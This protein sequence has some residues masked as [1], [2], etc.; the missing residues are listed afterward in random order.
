M[1]CSSI[2]WNS[3]RILWIEEIPQESN[4]V[5]LART[6]DY[7]LMSGPPIDICL[8]FPNK[9]IQP[10]MMAK[11][12]YIINRIVKQRGNKVFVFEATPSLL[13]GLVGVCDA[14]DIPLVTT[15]DQIEFGKSSGNE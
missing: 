1:V 10:V 7:Q 13:D 6:F 4:V 12:I 2:Q 15:I 9:S 14:L 8:S 5:D 3:C 11:A